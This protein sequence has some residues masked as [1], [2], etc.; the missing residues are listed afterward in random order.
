M[1]NISHA[2]PMVG[3]MER[4]NHVHNPE[5]NFSLALAKVY[6]QLAYLGQ[7][8]SIHSIKSLHDTM[9]LIACRSAHFPKTLGLTHS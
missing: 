4:Q 1:E 9:K 3:M 5:G 6:F 7:H 8:T 2:G